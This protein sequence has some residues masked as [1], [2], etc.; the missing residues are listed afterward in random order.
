MLLRLTALPLWGRCHPEGMTDEANPPVGRE[1][2]LIL[3]QPIKPAILSKAEGFSDLPMKAL[4]VEWEK[5]STQSRDT[6]A[7]RKSV[8]RFFDS[9]ALRS[10]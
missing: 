7:Y 1:L 5:V 4:P 10:E 3:H 9:A 6:T 2:L 8:R